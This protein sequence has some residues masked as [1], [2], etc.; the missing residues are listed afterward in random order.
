[1]FAR[2]VVILFMLI[3]AACGRPEFGAT[4]G[5]GDVVGTDVERASPDGDDL[6]GVTAPSDDDINNA[7]PPDVSPSPLDPDPQGGPAPLGPGEFAFHAY[8]ATAAE[9]LN[10]VVAPHGLARSLVIAHAAAGPEIASAVA[11]AVSTYLGDD[12][13]RRFNS[14]DL[15]LDARQSDASFQMVSAVWAQ[16]DVA[17]E[18]EMVDVLAMYLGL[19]LRLIDMESAPEDAR[20]QINNWYSAQTNGRISDV[21]GARTLDPTTRFVIT[22]ATWFDG[23]WGFGGF[24]PARTA[25]ATFHGEASNVEVPMMAT[26]AAL[27]H[28]GDPGGME[29]VVMPFDNGFSLIAVL[30]N[31]LEAF[32]SAV[33]VGFL[34]RILAEAQPQDVALRFPRLEVSD[35]ISLSSVA[36]ALGLSLMFAPDA[37]YLGFAD[38][39]RLDDAHQRSRI[40][41]DELGVTGE[42]DANDEGGSGAGDPPAAAALELTFDRP[43]F[44]AVRDTQTGNYLF[45]GRVAQP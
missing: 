21:L 38:E 11:S 25:N 1:M 2:L 45:L 12:I 43:F 10:V 37:E 35:R 36:D 16:D 40:A 29:A 41:F 3:T 9:G 19:Q 6:G 14:T 24:D 27:L 20:N 42:F 22:D 28:F 32:E 7:T 8:R 39:T 44:F 18:Q 34:D 5:G 30:P 15:G 31:D 4:S 33:D 13:Y 17:V 23:T 26:D